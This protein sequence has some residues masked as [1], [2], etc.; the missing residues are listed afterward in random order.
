MVLSNKKFN[1]I[2]LINRFLF[3]IL[4]NLVGK[5]DGDQVTNASQ[6]SWQV[7]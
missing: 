6:I 1:F 4:P 3:Y 5:L 2:L 7:R